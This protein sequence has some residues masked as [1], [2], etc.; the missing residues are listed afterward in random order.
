MGAVNGTTMTPE[1]EPLCERRKCTQCRHAVK[2]QGTYGYQ[3]TAR[4]CR[5]PHAM[6]GCTPERHEVRECARGKSGRCGCAPDARRA[7]GVV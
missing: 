3:C 6:I 2:P 4:K 7:A 5:V 1:R